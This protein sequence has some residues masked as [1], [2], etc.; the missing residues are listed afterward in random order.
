[1][2]AFALCIATVVAVS[3]SLVML[4][5]MFIRYMNDHER[6]GDAGWTFLV[7][8]VLIGALVLASYAASA[9][10]DLVGSTLSA[11]QKIQ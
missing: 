9:T 8:L 7:G 5:G 10:Y 6:D 11:E 2:T 1:M 3:A 4:T